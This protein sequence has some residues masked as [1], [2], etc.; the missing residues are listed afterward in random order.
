MN[1]YKN[2]CSRADRRVLDALVPGT[3]SIEHRQQLPDDIIIALKAG[4]EIGLCSSGDFIVYPKHLAQPNLVQ[5]ARDVEM[6]NA[7]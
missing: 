6:M 4:Y 5:T 1:E 7:P 3:A 2:S